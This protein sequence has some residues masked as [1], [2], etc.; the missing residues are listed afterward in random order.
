MKMKSKIWGVVLVLLAVFYALSQ[1]VPGLP[2]ISGIK[3]IISVGLLTIMIPNIPKL[4]FGSVLMPGAFIIL[5]YKSEIANGLGLENEISSVVILFSAIIGSIGLDM[6]FADKKRNRRIEKAKKYKFNKTIIFDS[7]DDVIDGYAKDVEED[8]GT[9]DDN[10]I[11][12]GNVTFS[13]STKYINSD[14]FKM[15]DFECNFGELKVY[16]DKANIVGDRADIK[17]E[18]NFGSMILYVPKNWKVNSS[19]ELVCAGIKEKGDHID[20]AKTLNI[21]GEVNFGATTI[22]YV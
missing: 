3:L 21:T 22:I 19:V 12:K 10:D 16:F 4:N 13:S 11:V 14:N 2:H 6:I 18:C 1:F 17:I 15:G 5:L 20:G 9:I 7:A 8:K